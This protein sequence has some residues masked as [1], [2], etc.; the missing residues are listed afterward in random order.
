[1]ADK[2]QIRSLYEEAVYLHLV[3]TGHKAKRGFFKINWDD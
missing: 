2:E 1:M 3:H